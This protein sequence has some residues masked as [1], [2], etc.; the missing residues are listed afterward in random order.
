MS[1]YFDAKGNYINSENLSL[2]EIYYRGMT[3]GYKKGYI[4]AQLSKIPGSQK[5]AAT[6]ETDEVRELIE[7]ERLLDDR[8]GTLSG[9]AHE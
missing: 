2:A 9:R 4:A 8:D 6:R 3:E 7:E 1:N 5:P